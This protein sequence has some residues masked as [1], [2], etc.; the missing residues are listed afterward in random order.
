MAGTSHTNNIL[1][2]SKNLVYTISQR[3]QKLFVNTYDFYVNDILKETHF[4][5]TFDAQSVLQEKLNKGSNPSR[6]AVLHKHLRR[7][8]PLHICVALSGSGGDQMFVI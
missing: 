1:L 3:Q 4:Q 5:S 2:L 6:K 8:L 7:C